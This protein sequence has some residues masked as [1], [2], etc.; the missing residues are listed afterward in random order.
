MFRHF[1]PN[2]EDAAVTTT[3]TNPAITGCCCLINRGHTNQ[4]LPDML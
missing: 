3:S 2:K 4:A 1:A